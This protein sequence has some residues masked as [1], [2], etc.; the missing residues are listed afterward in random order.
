MFSPCGASYSVAWGI[1]SECWLKDPSERIS[2]AE[3][4]RRFSDADAH[5][6]SD[7]D[8]PQAVEGLGT[9]SGVQLRYQEAKKTLKKVY[10][11][12][13]RIT[14]PS[15]M[16]G[17]HALTSLEKF[18]VMEPSDEQAEKE[19][20]RAYEICSSVGY[21]MMGSADALD[22]LGHVYLGQLKFGEAERAF[23]EA[24]EIYS[25]IDCNM[26]I[27]NA[28]DGLGR[29]CLAQRRYEEAR[30]SFREAYEIHIS[31]DNNVGTADA[32]D[33]LGC[34][35]LAQL[36]Y[37]EAKEAWK[38]AQKINDDIGDDMGV[39]NALDGLGHICLAQSKHEEGIKVFEE[40][41]DIYSRIGSHIGVGNASRSLGALYNHLGRYK[42]AITSLYEAY[43]AYDVDDAINDQAMG[44][45]DLARVYYAQGRYCEA[46]YSVNEA[47]AIWISTSDNKGQAGALLL[48]ER[49]LSSQFKYYDAAKIPIQAEAM[50]SEAENEACRAAIFSSLGCMNLALANYADA[51]Q[52]L[53]KARVSYTVIEDKE[54]ETKVL[55]SL[56]ELYAMQDSLAQAKSI[57]IDAHRIY[58][59]MDIPVGEIFAKTW[60]FIDLWDHYCI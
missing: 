23:R 2:I 19:H 16:S 35:Y 9:I 40:A 42:E 11:V 6:C 58:A 22:G 55:E 15:A 46:E 41:R 59:Q 24:L 17:M 3:V 8:I 43:S 20:M 56:I 5:R 34:T 33:S 52:W 28:S 10:E 37:E 18:S 31:I 4:F 53:C 47:L 57:C 25:R 21:Q 7:M 30:R 44:L 39:A 13:C 1:A 36:R 12:N 54:G 32:L 48:L 60:E 27:A 49:I 50:L 29:T 26:G 14:G 38:E 51:E 45:L